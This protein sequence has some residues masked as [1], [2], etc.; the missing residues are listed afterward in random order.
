[1]LMIRIV[2]FISGLTLHTPYEIPEYCQG[3]PML[4]SS[5]VA[6]NPMLLPIAITLQK[7]IRQIKATATAAIN[8]NPA[9]A[10]EPKACEGS[11]AGGISAVRQA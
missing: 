9:S 1:M 3:T 11:S 8:E 6:D 7:N 4:V 10:Y 2:L 5:I